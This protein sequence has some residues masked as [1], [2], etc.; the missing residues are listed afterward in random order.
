MSTVFLNA[1]FKMV[2]TGT[3]IENHLGELWSLFRFINP[4]LLGSLDSFNKRFAGPI[5]AQDD[6]LARQH[7]KRLVQPFILRRLKTEVLTE[8]PPR[9]E[10][11][12]TVPQSAEEKVF[13]EALRRQA[14][15]IL[16]ASDDKPGQQQL[17]VLA[18]IM[19]LRRACCNTQLEINSDC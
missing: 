17:R 11:T 12:I 5:E 18:E 1:K 4:G 2:A 6:K 13:Y 3:P 7:L 8:L 16:A 15:E 14:I 9:T 19:R 10:I